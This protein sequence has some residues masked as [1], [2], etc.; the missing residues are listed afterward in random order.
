V[1]ASGA[2]RTIEDAMRHWLGRISI[3]HKF[4]VGF[5]LIVILMIGLG[6]FAVNRLG[7]VEQSAA[8]LRDNALRSTVALS[9]IGQAAERLRSVLLMLVTTVAEQ[10]R[11]ALL[12]E[13]DAREHQVLAAIELYRPTITEPEEQRLAD[14]FIA[15]WANHTK[16]TGQLVGMMGQVQPDILMGLFNGRS[17]QAMNAFRDA[18]GADVDFNMQAGRQAADRGEALGTSARRWILGALAVSLLMCLFGGW[19]MIAGVIR[20]ITAMGVSI[21]GLAQHDTSVA[22]VGLARH[23]EIGAIARS[24]ER[25]RMG[26]IE[27]DQAAAHH[28]TEQA[29]RERRSGELE[30]L[31]HGFEQ[32]VGQLAG[33]LSGAASTLETTARSMSEMAGEASRETST[34]AVAAEHAGANV[35]AVADAANTLAVAIAEIGRQGAESAD[36]ASKAVADAR[37]TDGVVQVLSVGAQKIEAVLKLI[38]DVAG[39]T[40]LLAL[41]ATIEAARAGDAGKGFAVVAAEVKGLAGQTA[42]ATQEI[43]GQVRQIQD[44][45]RDTV[46]AVKGIG[47]VI[48]RLGAIAASM[49]VAVEQ[50]RAAT[51]EIAQNAQQ[52]ARGTHDVTA[53][54]EQVNR[55]ATATG[56]SAGQVLSEATDL[57]S[58][59]EILT[60]EMRGF[61]ARVRAI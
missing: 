45:T 8:E 37:R 26:I 17:L 60:T 18:L 33:H 61:A 6:G 46:D 28:A 35:N 24:V 27:A 13:V 44:A 47:A 40:N 2:R 55:A 19:V 53:T 36:I 52:A 16:Q 22:I 38:G 32:Q 51:T 29:A 56:T 23:D 41:N 43:A 7:A 57:A 4:M 48:E 39:K 20:P 15:A 59:A 58:R 30:G 1:P 31:V 3:R 49:S 50:Q 21:R 34:A 25:F 14:A 10:R 5:A 54:I 9:R 11:N 12:A 42:K